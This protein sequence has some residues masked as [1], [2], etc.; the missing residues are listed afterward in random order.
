MDTREKLI[1]IDGSGYIFRAYF[2]IQRLSTSKGVPTNAVFGFVNMLS[3]VLDV[4]K[5]TKLAIAFDTGKATF[6]KEIYPEYKA[7]R[8]SAP[9]DL[10]SQIPMIHR[11]VDCFGIHRVEA[12][13]YE[14]D[15]VIGTLARQAVAAGYRVEIITADKDLMQLVDENVTLFD[16]MKDKRVDGAAVVEKFGVKP[17]QVIDFLALMGDASDNIPGVSGVGEKTAAELI[18]QFGSIDGI[19]ENIDQIKQQ[20]RRETLLKE[21]DLA[22]LSRQLATVKCDLAL[23]HEW[24]DLSYHGPRQEQLMAFFKELEFTN[25]LKRFQK[26]GPTVPETPTEVEADSAAEAFRQ[27]Y[28]VVREPQRLSEVV[29]EL[30]KGQGVSVDTETTSLNP[31]EAE[32]VGIS[33]CAQAGQAY[34]VPVGHHEPG[35]PGMRSS[36]QMGIAEARDI[37][38]PLLEDAKVPKLGQNLKYDIQIF[39]RWGIQ[40]RGVV[41]DTLLESYLLDPDEPHNLDS[42][43][44]RYLNHSNIA[45]SD[46]TGTGKKQISF[47][48]VPI[49]R[50]AAYSGEDADVAL[51]LHQKLR[52]DI[53]KRGLE[54]LFQEIEMPLLEVL[55]DMEYC[56]VLV[57]SGKLREMARELDAEIGVTE[58]EIFRMAGETFNIHSPKQLSK[59]L[60]E[61]LGLPVV[62]KTKTGLST[63]ESVLHELSKEHEICQ[64][65]VKYRELEK[66]KSTYVEALLTQMH[67]QTHRVHTN[68]NQTVAAT[69][70]LSSSNPNLQNIPVG[71]KWDVRAAFIAG[72]GK[73]LLSAD[74]SQVELRLLADMSD[75]TEL[76]RAFKNDED[77]HDYTGRLIFGV[78]KIDSDQRRIAKTINFGVVYGQTPFGLSQ[79]LKISPK[80]AKDFIERYFARYSGVQR[81]MRQVVEDTRQRGY[82]MTVLG[83]RR[84][85]P[86]INSQNRMRREMAERA[87]INT[88]LQGTAADMIKKAMVSIHRRLL[89]EGLATRMILQV[90]DELVFE[91]PLAEKKDVQAM[92]REEM[93]SALALKVPLKVDMG[94]GQTWRD[95]DS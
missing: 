91:V 26:E 62:K 90:H 6:R 61:K 53:S 60:F 9:E 15:D 84:Y 4:E 30:R 65:I 54:P 58:A 63:D 7:N 34:Y 52:P 55:A 25:L 71:S 87:A 81:Y 80:E 45:Y 48:E 28:E 82:A 17:E 46:V 85:L 76:V 64:W 27:N 89:R 88:P 10:V 67:Q 92:V 94:W 69:G 56:G 50:A 36:G 72:E 5:P 1:I 31:Q 95:T 78:E 43:A 49:D 93:E 3:K 70:R 57:D 32:M 18:K 23:K 33:L 12:P 47:A 22:Y 24:S 73:E 19:Y 20:K 14:A 16:T 86:E 51:R 77:V 75:D 66:L 59:I 13:G 40:V 21:K 74:Y 68:Y 38:K 2:A 44:R 37:L 35:Q 83:R 29:A 79:T 42:L 11:A 41:A 8:Q 39:K